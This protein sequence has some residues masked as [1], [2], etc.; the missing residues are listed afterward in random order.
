MAEQYANPSGLFGRLITASLLN[1]ANQKSNE[2]VYNALDIQFKHRFL[3]VG[4][5]GGSL[6]F[7]IA[8]HSGS[9]EIYG[10]EK[11]QSM[12]RWAQTKIQRDKKQSAIKLSLGGV[13]ALPYEDAYFDRICSVNTLYFWPDL[14]QGCRE[15]ARVSADGALV[16][17]GFGSGEKLAASGYTDK[18][19]N[20]YKPEFIHQAMAE[21]GLNL[22]KEQ[23][24]ERKSK[25]PFFVSTYCKN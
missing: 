8:K 4:F 16:V 24:I 3:E 9:S 5:G 2:A 7:Q 25:D 10:L 22:V 6:L 17:L 19:F 23:R 21:A 13:D 15:L 11:S 14:Q 20:F 1:R 18:G 12:L